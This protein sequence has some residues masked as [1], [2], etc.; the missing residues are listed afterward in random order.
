METQVGVFT[1]QLLKESSK[2]GRKKKF[3]SA[4]A[5]CA[6]TIYLKFRGNICCTVVISNSRFLKN[7][8]VINML[9]CSVSKKIPSVVDEV[10]CQ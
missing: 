5:H 3:S 4:V 10:L 8:H 6:E 2:I 7:D 9:E 1:L